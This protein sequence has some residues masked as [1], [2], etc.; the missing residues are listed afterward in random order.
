[1]IRQHNRLLAIRQLLERDEVCRDIVRYLVFHREAADTIRGIAE[2]W[3]K[4]DIARTA[5]ALTKLQDHG[6]VRSSLVQGATSVYSFTKNP[7]LRET[8]RQ[9]V[10]AWSG[11]AP[12]EHR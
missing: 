5:Q 8:L 2:W 4:R 10:S 7:L 3:I 12:A 9:Y 1:M 11:P 6:V